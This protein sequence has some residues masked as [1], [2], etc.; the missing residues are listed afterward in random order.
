M[1]KVLLLSVIAVMPVT[2]RSAGRLWEAV[3]EP[4][5]AALSVVQPRIQPLRFE[6]YRLDRAN[7]REVLRRAPVEGTSGTDKTQTSL[8]LPLPGGGVARFRI[9]ETAVMHPRL[10]A[11]FPEIKTY[12]GRGID[13]PAATA[14]ID[15]THQGFHAQVFSPGSAMYVDPYVAGDRTLYVAYY[16]RDY[17]ATDKRFRCLLGANARRRSGSVPPP[18]LGAV[19]GATLRTYRLACAVT[20]EYTQYHGGT[21]PLAMSAIV[22]TVNRVTGIYQQE[23]SVRLQLVANNDSLVY[24]NGGTDPYSNEDG[25]AMLTENQ[26]NV[27]AVIGSANYDIGHVFS[28]GGGGIAGLGVVCGAD[29]AEGVTGNENPVGDP[30]DVDYV[31]HEMGHQ[32][33]ANHTFNGVAGSCAGNR[34]ASTAYEPGSGT[35]IMGY[36]GICDSDDTQDHSDPFF[37][38][39]S[40]EEITG[41]VTTGGGGSCAVQTPTTNTPPTVEAGPDYTIPKNTPFRLTASGNDVDGD[42]L[43]YC[44]EQ[45]DLGPEQAVSAADNGSSPIF[46]CWSPTQSPVRTFPRLSDLL[47]STTVIGEQLP[48]LARTMEFRC[49]VRD[50]RPSGGGVDSDDMAVTVD[51]DSGPFRVTFPNTAQTLAGGQLVTWDVA[52]TDWAPVSAA[53]VDIMLSTNG[54]L[55][56][57]ISLATAVPNDGSQGV[58]LPDIDNANARIMVMGSDNVFFDVSDADFTITP[59]DDLQIVP[60]TELSSQGPQGGPFAPPCRTYGL[61]NS[62]A[63]A[64]AWTSSVDV[65]WLTVSPGH[66]S[67]DAAGTASLDVCVGSGA[68]SL[69]VGSYAGTVTFSNM[70]SG[71][72][73]ERSVSLEVVPLGGRLRFASAGF[74]VSEGGGMATVTVERVD[75]ATGAA[76]VSYATSNDTALSGADYTTSTGRLNW[77]DGDS[78]AKAFAVPIVDDGGM[79]ASETLRLTLSMPSGAQLGTPAVALLTIVDDDEPSCTNVIAD[80]TFEAG[81][82]WPAWTVQTSDTFGTPLYHTSWGTGD[83]YAPYAGDNWAYFGAPDS[84]NAETATM[85]QTVTI[86]AHTSVRLEFMLWIGL[87]TPTYADTLGVKVDG[88]PV[89]SVTEPAVAES[90]YSLRTVDLTAY[91]DGGT[92]AILF[93]F[94]APPGA[95]FSDFGIDNVELW[96]CADFDGDGTPDDTDPDDDNDGIPDYWEILHGLNP[97]DE[98]DA[99]QDG[100]GDLASNL[101]EYH[102]DTSPTNATSVLRLIMERGDSVAQQELRFDSSTGRVYSVSH[103]ADLT[104]GGWSNLVPTFPGTGGERRVTV[105]NSA[106]RAFY[107]LN[108]NRP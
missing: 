31:A 96:V 36:A 38:S 24:T 37:H 9:E 72:G 3:A 49:T 61:T 13:D 100:D 15:W 101:D 54:G 77:A 91:A 40:H 70:T 71:V 80:S 51:A 94:Y 105:T 108:A 44:W 81:D 29:K 82:P 21:V 28:T 46:R 50:N 98:D 55:A 58:V 22:T 41:F 20:G 60:F 42:P 99:A 27:D 11:K 102:A 95:G 65:A 68:D 45:Q 106:A 1:W 85:G 103:R 66:G 84:V 17:R 64:L 5:R 73:Q 93:E 32:F 78:S 2:S 83:T 39:A 76:V 69:S 79:E 86:R 56:F 74:S 62:G 97:R 48:V 26:S 33:G 34:N 10:A 104:A 89:W 18:P 59:A 14:R 67:L 75:D 6:L 43:T 25:F 88:T 8:S 53:N 107:R 57:S 16:K 92:H 90:G 63:S 47:A 52:G 87:V 7:V 19:S 35:T 30:F 4:E 23:L 12:V